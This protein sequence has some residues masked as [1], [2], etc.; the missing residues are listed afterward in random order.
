MKKTELK[1]YLGV[2][3]TIA[4]SNRLD[5]L[6]DIKI[7]GGTLSATNLDIYADL[8]LGVVGEAVYDSKILDLIT[9]DLNSDLTAYKTHELIDFP[10]FMDEAPK[11]QINLNQR[12]SRGTLG[13]ILIHALDFVSTDTMR[14]ALTGVWTQNGEIVATD[15]FR[16]YASDKVIDDQIG[17]YGL[18]APLL[19]LYKKVAKLGEWA[20][21]ITDNT[22]VLTNGTLTIR[23]K[24]I[25]GTFPKVRELMNGN[26]L[27][28]HEVVLPYAQLKS[29]ISKSD[30]TLV[31]ALDGTLTLEGRPLPISA[32]VS[33]KDYEYDQDGYRALLCGLAGDKIG[34]DATLL[35]AFRADNG[36]IT[37]RINPDPKNKVYSVVEPHNTK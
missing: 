10:D 30:K 9:I 29:A 17:E 19:K 3:K 13:E 34:V 8:N 25:A 7:S 36:E 24:Q 32:K 15:G 23:S 22:F 4:K 12:W 31:I 1:S 33:A 16:A 37:L 26:R 27:Y 21:T 11:H 2:L 5:T 20:L 28:S 6:K 18:P 35:S 14:P